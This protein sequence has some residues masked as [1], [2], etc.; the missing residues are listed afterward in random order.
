VDN[1]KAGGYDR[2]MSKRLEDIL[3]SAA[4]LSTTE[5]AELAAALLASLDSDPE[6]VVEVAWN[7][8]IQRRVERVRTGAA[9]GRPWSEVRK[10]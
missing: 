7:A 5:R 2:K 10:A 6:E 9:T 4:K 3:R 8:E 1:A